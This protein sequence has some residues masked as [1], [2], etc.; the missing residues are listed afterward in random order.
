MDNFIKSRNEIINNIRKLTV[1][2]G[3][4]NINDKEEYEI[5]SKKPTS[6]YISGILF[7]KNIAHIS[8]LEN[9]KVFDINESDLNDSETEKDEPKYEEYFRNEENDIDDSTN[10]YVY[11]D[12]DN[13]KINMMNE[14]LKSAMGITFFTKQEI[15]KIYLIIESAVYRRTTYKDLSLNI[16]NELKDYFKFNELK[17]IV[18]IDDNKIHLLNNVKYELFKEKIELFENQLI[19]ENIQKEIKSK[20]LSILRKLNNLNRNSYKRYPLRNEPCIDLSALKGDKSTLT[21]TV[22]F[23]CEDIKDNLELELFIKKCNLKNSTFTYT[24]VLSNLNT[25]NT[26]VNESIY[27]KSFFQTKLTIDTDINENLVFEELNINSKQ[28]FEALKDEDK[29]LE[30]LYRFKKEYAIGHGISVDTDVDSS[31]KGYISTTYLPIKEVRKLQFNIDELNDIKFILDMKNLSKHSSFSKDEMLNYLYDFANIYL[32]WINNLELKTE[33]LSEEFKSVAHKHISKC[34]TAHKR[35]VNG[36]D[37]L[38]SN[39]DAYNAFLFANEAMYIQRAHSNVSQ[40]QQNDNIP[41]IAQSDFA[42]DDYFLESNN[43]KFSWRPFQ[44]AFLLMNLESITDPTCEFR[45]IVDILWVSTG[46]GKTEAYLGLSAFTIFYRRLKHKDGG[47]GMSVLM[48]YTLR[49]LTSQQFSR[50]STLICASELIR[51]DN[52]D[53]LG[54]KP[55]T[56]GLWIGGSQTPNDIKNADKALNNLNVNKS[57]ENPFVV[58]NCPWCGTQLSRDKENR[59]VGYRCEGHG[60]KKEFYIKCTSHHCK[61]KD[62]LPIQVVDEMIYK[63]PPTFLIGTVDKFAMIPWIKEAGSLFGKGKLPPEL[64]IQDELHLISGPLGSIVGMYET[65]IDSLCT[66]DGIKPKIITATATIRNSYEQCKQLFARDSLQFPPPGIRIEDSFFTREDSDDFGRIYIGVMPYGKKLLHA[67]STLMSNM[68]SSVVLNDYDEDILNQYWTLLSY[69]NSLKEI[70]SAKFQISETVESEV[71]SILKRFDSVLVKRHLRNIEEL[72]SR[73]KSSSINKTL[74]KI[75][76]DYSDANKEANKYATD[77]LLASNMISVGLDV[78]R[79]NMMMLVQQPKTTSEYIQATSRVGRKYPGFVV[80]LYN[81]SRSRDISCF[82]KFQNYHNAF[83]KYVEPTSVTSFSEPVI[84]RALH[85]IVISLIRHSNESNICNDTPANITQLDLEIENVKNTIL[86]RLQLISDDADEYKY[87]EEAIDRLINRWVKIANSCSVE[88][89]V[90]GTILENKHSK[91]VSLITT[92]D[93]DDPGDSIPTLTS[94]RS[95]SPSLGI[96]ILKEEE[97]ITYEQD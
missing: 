44:L 49:L 54:N 42:L 43:Y 60:K 80:A 66:R 71:S 97:G 48:R 61:F 29:S 63:N 58:L 20:L 22:K 52:I 36:I 70:G 1:G 67:Q 14:L 77:I 12:R 69:F 38:S 9:E 82:E 31:G 90:Y 62:R 89:F 7:P 59:D 83:Y 85:A 45:D 91:N 86:S 40:I 25:V 27:K 96:D 4:E 6:R 34:K 92:F 23:Y 56:L 3:S 84:D 47:D 74:K 78:S 72:T 35:I 28:E 26:F 32:E 5:I 11:D 19:S 68:L 75:E 17:D 2:P 41:N 30:L 37:T 33:Y 73:E 95:V 87:A 15:D 10:S 93:N 65:V 8:D 50:A 64:I 51:K 81:P 13:E 79:L 88:E 21:T 55:I 39:E 53:M 18:S 94:M 57:S 76:I 16:E 46:G 24:V